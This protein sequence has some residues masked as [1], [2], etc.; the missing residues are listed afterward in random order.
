[1]Q[2]PGYGLPRI[3]LLG[4]RLNNARGPLEVALLELECPVVSVG[5]PRTGV[6]AGEPLA[7]ASA[8]AERFLT[9][10]AHHD[11]AAEHPRAETHFREIL[12]A[13]GHLP[14]PRASRDPFVQGIEQ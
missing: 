2:S 11:A 1:M 4:S 13:Q 14:V 10:V 9:D 6:G 5:Q 12:G 7:Q 8:R 3:R